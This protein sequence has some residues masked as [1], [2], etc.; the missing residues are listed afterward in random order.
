MRKGVKKRHDD[1][2][3]DPEN[4][5]ELETCLLSEE[6]RCRSL[7]DLRSTE[8][9]SRE[10]KEFVRINKSVNDILGEQIEDVREV[11]HLNMVKFRDR[12]GKLDDLVE[13]GEML[14][15]S[16]QQF[17]VISNKVR[18]KQKLRLWRTR[19]LVAVAVAV[20]IV[21]LIVVIVVVVVSQ[22]DET[23]QTNL[24]LGSFNHGPSNDT[25]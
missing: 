5:E 24:Y 3:A 7:E 13:K 23:P 15:A 14:T 25:S 9:E 18:Q 17:Q 6:K 10:L 4:P 1:L 16:C 19:I 20:G 8:P 2:D 11:M 22:Q 21:V 12:N